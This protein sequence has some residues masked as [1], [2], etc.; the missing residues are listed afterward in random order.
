MTERHGKR[1]AHGALPHW[2]Y[3]NVRYSSCVVCLY[4]APCAW[5]QLDQAAAAAVARAL[6]RELK[7]KQKLSESTV[8]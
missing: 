4:A 7:Q 2:L 8:A 5:L 6:V 3:C 1:R